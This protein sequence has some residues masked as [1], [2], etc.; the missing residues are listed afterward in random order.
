MSSEHYNRQVAKPRRYAKAD[1]VFPVRSARVVAHEER[2][3]YDDKDG[4]IGGEVEF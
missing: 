4:G 1:A 2:Q 3:G